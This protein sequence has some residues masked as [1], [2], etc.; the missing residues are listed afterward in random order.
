MVD[1]DW[2]VFVV[3]FVVMYGVLWF[4]PLGLFRNAMASTAGTFLSNMGLSVV[5]SANHIGSK[6]GEFSVSNDCLGI[7]SIS[8]LTSLLL[9]TRGIPRN[10]KIIWSIVGLVVFPIWNMLRI[11]LSLF[12]GRENFGVYHFTLWIVS[13]VFILALYLAAVKTSFKKALS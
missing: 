12:L 10:Q 1:I 8:I 9:A 4:S 11:V 5:V 13:V 2:K 7:S 6:F 3:S